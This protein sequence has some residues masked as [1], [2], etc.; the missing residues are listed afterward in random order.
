MV[1]RGRS[2][3]LD[4]CGG[5]GGEKDDSKKEESKN[6]DPK[7]EDKKEGLTQSPGGFS[8]VTSD[9]SDS[10]SSVFGDLNNKFSDIK[11]LKLGLSGALK[12]AFT[13]I[14]LSKKLT[15][16]WIKKENMTKF[17][18]QV[19]SSWV[20]S[21]AAGYLTGMLGEKYKGFSVLV[22]PVLT[23]AGY[24][25][26]FKYVLSKAAIKEGKAEA[27]DDKILI[28]FMTSALAEFAAGG[29][30]NMVGKMLSDE[31]TDA[32]G[33]KM[34]RTPRDKVPAAEQGK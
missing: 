19:I 11:F 21:K 12:I 10:V 23:G 34:A 31:R 28:T 30:D 4:D 26:A 13:K 16:G 20:A 7:K 1:R 22:E 3:C 32:Y 33:N 5:G 27:G 15:E 24:A 25:L 14:Y 8:G 6:D 9:I 2:S 29:A 18:V 17:M